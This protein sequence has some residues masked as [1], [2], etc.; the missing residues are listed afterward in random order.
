MEHNKER[1]IHFLNRVEVT[2]DARFQAEKRL[3][4]RHKYSYYIISLLSLFVIIISM[5]PSI[6]VDLTT[7]QNQILLAITILNSVFIIITTLMD[8]AGEYSLSA[9]FMNR[10]ARELSTIFNALKLASDE[11]K[12]DPKFIKTQQDRYQDVLNDC[13]VNH[14]DIDYLSVKLTKPNLFGHVMPKSKFFKALMF[15]RLYIRIHYVRA[16]WWFPHLAMVIFSLWI[17]ER[18]A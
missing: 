1:Y 2:R 6:E 5:I 12:M 14:D 4:R 18:Y 8:G 3:L 11:Q 9:H 7:Q 15:T 13:P 17:M 16:R 10:S